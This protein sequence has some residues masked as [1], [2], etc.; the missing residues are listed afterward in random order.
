LF[1]S[2]IADTYAD[3]IMLAK[4]NSI[5]EQKN[6]VNVTLLD[7][8]NLG[9]VIPGKDLELKLPPFDDSILDILESSLH[10]IIFTEGFSDENNSTIISAINLT[11]DDL[12]REKENMI[13]FPSDEL[14]KS[15]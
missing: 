5:N 14:K 15:V 10:V 8:D 12:N 4:V 2:L 3:G 9:S 6:K 13:K 11:D 7:V 1:I